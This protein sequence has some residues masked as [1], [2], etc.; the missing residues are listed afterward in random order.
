MDKHALQTSPLVLASTT[1]T[2]GKLGRLPLVLHR[3][4]LGLTARKV[5][6][7]LFYDINSSVQYEVSAICLPL[8]DCLRKPY[9]L[10]EV[11][12]ISLHIH[13]LV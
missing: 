4:H 5:R 3:V 13:K 7:S 2:V 12:I 1:T 6:V 8:F 10:T 11:T 9:V